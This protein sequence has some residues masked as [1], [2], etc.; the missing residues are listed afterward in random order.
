MKAGQKILV[1]TNYELLNKILGKNFK[2]FFKGYYKISNDC[3]IWMISINGENKFGWVNKYSD[4]NTITEEY[5]DGLP[6]PDTIKVGLKYKKRLVFDKVKKPNGTMAY[7]V[8]RGLYEL[9]NEG[10]YTYRVL[11]KVSDETDLF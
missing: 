9:T 1:S 6:Y 10:S 2:G 5:V 7:F 4:D 11:R 8:F 3:Y